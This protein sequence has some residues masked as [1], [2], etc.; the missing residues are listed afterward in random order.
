MPCRKGRKSLRADAEASTLI[1]IESRRFLYH[2][3]HNCNNKSKNATNKAHYPLPLLS[4][5]VTFVSEP[6]GK[7][8]FLDPS[9]HYLLQLFCL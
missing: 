3:T 6:L 2:I 1:I 7:K 5:S 8:C 9:F 4:Q